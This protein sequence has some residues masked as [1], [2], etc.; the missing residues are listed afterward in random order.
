MNND[1]VQFFLA[2]RQRPFLIMDSHFA[3]NEGELIYV[4]GKTYKVLARSF[5]VDYS[6][7][8]NQCM[9]CNLIVETA[10]E[11]A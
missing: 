4:K 2:D 6:E 3:P 7:T 1:T 9:R 8:P 5:S 10:K 11:K